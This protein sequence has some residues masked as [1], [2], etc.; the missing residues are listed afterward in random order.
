MENS[1]KKWKKSG[2]YVFSAQRFIDA[3]FEQTRKNNCRFWLATATPESVIAK[4]RWIL[5]ADGKE[6]D[7]DSSGFGQI[8][9]PRPDYKGRLLFL[10]GRDCVDQADFAPYFGPIPPEP[11][12]ES[13][14]SNKVFRALQ[15][16]GFIPEDIDPN[17]ESDYLSQVEDD[18]GRLYGRSGGRKAGRPRKRRATE[19]GVP[20]NLIY[21][22]P[23]VGQRLDEEVSNEADGLF[24]DSE[25]P[26]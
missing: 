16:L 18:L 8:P 21:G 19:V 6:V 2:K 17:A 13:N 7:L 3:E 9:D 20:T 22:E 15:D 25:L 10:S 5:A 1:L 11:V 12:K 14:L 26:F 4:Y 24:D 23:P